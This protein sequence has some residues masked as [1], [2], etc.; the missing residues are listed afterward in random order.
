MPQYVSF[1]HDIVDGRNSS[2]RP[3]LFEGAVEGHVLVKNTRNALPLKK[4]RMLSIFGYSAKNPDSNGFRPSETSWLTGQESYR[5]DLGFEE[6]YRGYYDSDTEIQYAVTGIAPNGTIYS[7]GGSGATSQFTAVSPFDA[8]VARADKDDTALIWDF[9]RDFPEVNSN[10]DACLVFG[11]AFATEGYDRPVAYDNHTDG[12]IT[13]I[14]SECGNTIVVLHN[15]G[16]RTV[17]GFVNHPNVTALFFG[18]L[19]GQDSGKAI[20]SLLYGDS[21]PS[22]KLP[23]TVARDPAHYPVLHPSSQWDEPSSRFT[24]F[25]QS[26]FT[27]GSYVDYR[28][29]DLHEDRFEPRYPFG[30]G[31]SYTTF[32]YGNLTIRWRDEATAVEP[33]SVASGRVRAGGPEDLWDVLVDVS[34][35][36]ENTGAVDGAEVAQL[37]VNIGDPGGPEWRLR[38]FDKPFI[39][40]GDKVTVRFELTRRDLSFWNVNAQKWQLGDVEAMRMFVGGHSRDRDLM[41]T[42]AVAAGESVSVLPSESAAVTSS[43]SVSMTPS[44]S[45]SVVPPSQTV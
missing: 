37:Y 8:L 38:G 24:N 6:T 32:A 30:F 42:V 35:E 34:A 7:G 12:L 9:E 26:N 43:E 31:L 1:P 25:P 3:T 41:G 5:L 11:N 28:H 21:N 14:A 39:E 44:K 10:S 15:A 22:G 27:E 18:H 20:V 4:P 36:V 13:R 45:V 40:S 2:F 19:P 23:Y 29:F 33:G 16:I 17:D